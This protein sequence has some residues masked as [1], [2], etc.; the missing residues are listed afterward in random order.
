MR[1]MLFRA[2]ILT[3]LPRSNLRRSA[4]SPG[5]TVADG[6]LP[7]L[8]KRI[9]SK[10]KMPTMLVLLED[11]VRKEFGP[12]VLAATRAVASEHATSSEVMPRACAFVAALGELRRQPVT[13]MARLVGE[14]LVAPLF[15]AA[16][17]IARRYSSTRAILLQVTSVVN[18][19]MALLLPGATAPDIDVELQDMDTLR[20]STIV[21]PELAALIE[22]MVLGSAAHFN[23]RVQVRRSES[24]VGAVVRFQVDAT[25]EPERRTGSGTPPSPPGV[26]RRTGVLKGA[27]TFLR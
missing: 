14:R 21:S 8:P 17:F 2:A 25:F 26:E 5:G 6:R 4:R 11:V 27:N 9:E 16:P 19:L 7:R 10:R 18:D 12:T 22:G 23:E 1:V 24:T 20:L 15:V 13:S 3:W